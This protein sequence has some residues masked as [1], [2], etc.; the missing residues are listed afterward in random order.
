M[1]QCL[2]V[3]FGRITRMSRN[4]CSIWLHTPILETSGRVFSAMF[5]LSMLGFA[6]GEYLLHYLCHCV[7]DS[8]LSVDQIL[9]L[10]AVHIL[11]DA[12]R[13]VVRRSRNSPV[14]TD[15]FVIVM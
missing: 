6:S 12:T 3:G 8:V 15:F 9:P 13:A 14:L 5:P 4:V 10:F 11:F 1:S 2:N 7:T